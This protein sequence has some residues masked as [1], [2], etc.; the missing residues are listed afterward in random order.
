[1]NTARKVILVFKTH[2]DIGFTDL[3]ARVLE[4]Y[5]DSFIPQ[6]V[7]I[8]FRVNN[9]TQ[10]RFV[11]TV[12]SYLIRHYLTSPGVSAERKIRLEEALWLGYVR[13]HGLSCTT[14]TELMDQDLFRYG[15]SISRLL[16][17][18]YGKKTIAAKMTDVPGHTAAMVPLMAEAGIEYLHIGVNAGSKVPAVPELFR[19]RFDGAEIVVNYAGVYGGSTSLP[20][21][22]VLEFVHT[23]DN[24]GP[25]SEAE[26]DE[27]YQRLGEKYPGAEINAGSLDEFAEAVRPFRKDL[28]VIEEEIGDT[29]IHGLSSDPLKTARLKKLLCL[30]NKW[31][32]NGSLDPTGEVY[33]RFM[34]P[35]L[36]VAEHTWGFNT[37]RYLQDF[38]NWKKAD[39]LQALKKDAVE[40][41][42]LSSRNRIIEGTWEKPQTSY[43]MFETAIA[44][45]RAYIASAVQALPASLAAEAE[46]ELAPAGTMYPGG[47]EAALK[48][49]SEAETG[50]PIAVG[51]W[52][53]T[54][55]KDGELAAIK[56]AALG[57]ERETSFGLFSY[58]VFDGK[59]ADD[60]VYAYA[61]DIKKYWE[62][63]E[64]D[65][66]KAG[67]RHAGS[68]KAKRH[69][70]QA[71]SVRIDG[72]ALI[73][74]LRMPPEACEEYG[75]PREPVIEHVLGEKTIDT[76][77]YLGGKD[78][79][80]I[81]EALWFGFGLG[82]ANPYRWRMMKMGR[83]VSPFEVVPGGNRKL[84]GVEE[85]RYSASDG[86]IRI[87][88]GESPNAT[89][90]GYR[91]FDTT[92]S[93]GD[94]TGNVNF[95]LYNN[96]WGTNFKQWFGEDLRLTWRSEFGQP[97][98]AF[99]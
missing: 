82:V 8:A 35:L 69:T 75:C 44:E 13:W 32:S 41:D 53:I 15:L 78:P 94:I 21:G 63:F 59:T 76:V 96:R 34:E 18:R 25:P 28:P 17:E 55:G 52:T 5:R 99:D 40:P 19:W 72:S 98:S 70:A 87:V 14:H 90:G 48:R 61:K 24:S 4:K 81:P 64:P 85:V 43:S 58:E 33:G 57:I 71:A 77:L 12:G 66:G 16:D 11:W 83:L 80:R 95:L 50:V 20:D 88:S 46:K 92:D 68:V 6:S 79:S 30:K 60:S 89:F 39:F 74:A 49:G 51:G 38:D 10:R 29:W 22:T 36:L 1:M 7:D 84:H 91:L 45:Q 86:S 62:W 27:L 26:L 67:L 42:K 65:F 3:A 56:N 54:V 23:N 2:L 31:I 9:A 97:G 73:I 47:R 37:Q 93:F